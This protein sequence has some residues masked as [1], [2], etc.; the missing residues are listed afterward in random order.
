MKQWLTGL[1]QLSDEQAMWQ[2]QMQ[3]DA[4]AFAHLLSR[5]QEP[6]R[7]M[8]A[9]MLGDE[10]KAE[11]MTQ[12]AFAKVYVR[13]K[14]FQHGARFST[15][16]WRVAVNLCIDEIRRIKRRREFSIAG[17]GQDA[18]ER[19]WE[20]L[21]S[22]LAHPD[23]AV[24]ALER[25]ALVKNAVQQLPEHYQAVVVL[26][27]YENL[28]FKEIAEVLGIPEGTVKSRMAEALAIL[29]ARLTGQRKSARRN[30]P[31]NNLP[32]KKESLVL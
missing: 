29:N 21:Q 22:D 3:D 23:A 17:E 8:C 25:A 26:R 5:W 18:P 31:G 15:F 27:H 4:E 24:E 11:D 2:V 9:R 12:E 6:V 14:E 32:R 19:P 13:R 7:R 20:E 28:K 30:W 10:H 1:F 16:V